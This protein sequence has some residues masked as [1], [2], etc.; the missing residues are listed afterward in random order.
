MNVL[1]RSVIQDIIEVNGIQVYY[2]RRGTGPTVLCIAGATGDAGHFSQIADRL[3]DEYTVITY[4]RR[5]NSRSS[6]SPGWRTTSASEQADDAAALLRAINLSRVT[7]FGT[8]SGA[9]IGLNL[10]LRYPDRVRGA[11]LHEP[12]LFAALADPPAVL[13]ALRPIIEGGM[14]TGGSRGAVEAFVRMVAGDAV[15]ESLSSN[16][17][18]RMLNNGDTLFQTEFGVLEAYRPDH[19]QLSRVGRPVA[20]LAGTETMPF[21]LEASAW[22]ANALNA[23]LETLPGGHAPYLACPGETA[24]SLRSLLR[25]L[26]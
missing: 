11:I 21:M 26:I 10:L 22:L 13:D 8:S 12:P 5:G 25:R 18:E 9:I 1:A 15:F 7:I 19:E 6:G 16:L 24:E 20:V 23:P 2:E 17:R 3:S 4:D 14:V